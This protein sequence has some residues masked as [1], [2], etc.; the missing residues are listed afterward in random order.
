MSRICRFAM[1]LCLL[2]CFFAI[3]AVAVP[4]IWYVDVDNT[5]DTQD[6]TSWAT[7]YTSIQNAINAATRAGVSAENPAELWVAE[8]RYSDGGRIVT[9][10]GVDTE[11]VI[12]LAAHVHIY[13]GFNGTEMARDERDWENNTTIIDGEGKYRCVVAQNIAMNTATLDGVTLQNGSIALYGDVA[14]R[15]NSGGGLF[16][17]KSSLT[18]MNCTFLKNKAKAGGGGVYNSGSSSPVLTNCTFLENCSDF[19]AGVYNSESSSPMLTNCTF[20][21]NRADSY[22]GGIRNR[23]SSPV[24]MDCTFSENRAG[25]YGGGMCNISSLPTL[26]NCIFFKNSSDVGGGIYNSNSSSATL[27]NCAFSENR[28][29]SHGGGMRNYISSPVLTNCTF[30]W[31]T[32]RYGAGMSNRDSSSPVLMNCTFSENSAGTDGDGIYNSESSL[33]RLK[34]CILWGSDEQIYN[35]GNDAAAVVTYSDIQQAAGVYPGT[36]N[37]NVLPSF[38]ALG[39]H[40]LRLVPGSPCIDVGTTTGAPDTDILGTARPQGAGVDMGA[41]EYFP[42][43]DSDNNGVSDRV[44]GDIDRD[45]D[46]VAD[47]LDLDNDGD[48]LRDDMEGMSDPDGDGTPNYNDM[49][50]D[51]DGIPDSE[52]RPVVFV[53]VDNTSGTEDGASWATAF[54]TIQAG[55][56][57]AFENGGAEVWVAAGVYTGNGRTVDIGDEDTENVIEV[58]EWAHIYGGFSGTETAR[59]ERDWVKNGTIIDG[60]RKRRCVIAQHIAAGAA[61]FDGFTLQKG[62]PRALYKTAC[63]GG[64]LYNYCSLLAVANCNF[65]ENSAGADGGGIYN[66][67]SSL[68]LTNCS[69]LR[70]SASAGGGIYNAESSSPILINCVFSEN[71]VRFRGGGIHNNASSP[72]LMNCT[73]WKNDASI[74]G[75]GVYNSSASS[76]VLTNCI[77]WGSNDQIC[78]DGSDSSP[79]ITYSDVQQSSGVY[80]G[81]GNINAMPQISKCGEHPWRIAL[82]SPCIDAGTA[83]AAPDT[84]IFGT[85]RPLGVGVDMGAHEYVGNEDSDCNGVPDKEEGG[86]DI[87][88]DGIVDAVD[89]DNDGDGLRDDIEGMGDIDGDGI[90]NYDD[91]DSDGDGISDS[92]E[93][94]VVFVDVDNTSGI[95]DGVSWATAF[96]TIQEGIDAAASN[97]GVD[98][99]VAQGSYTGNGRTVKIGGE[100]TENVIEL[101]EWTYLYGGFNG[102]EMQ[103][104]ERDWEKNTTIIDGE[105]LRRC[106]VAQHIVSCVSVFDGFVLQNG[107]TSASSYRF[108]GGMYNYDTSLLL[109]NC[110]FSRNT[111]EHRGG[112][113]YNED[114]LLTLTDCAFSDNTAE[115]GFGGGI[116]NEGSLL[117]L[118]DC[119][120]SDNTAEYRGGGIYNE[121]SL[122][123]LT[124]CTF[125]DNTADY[126]GGMYNNYSSL[127]LTD[128]TF[129]ANDGSGMYNT[130]S[131]ATLTGC[132]FSANDGGG[133]YNNYSSLTLTD[134]T[135]AKNVGGGMSN[136]YSSSP[137]LTDCIFLENTRQNGGGMYNVDSSPTLTDCSFSGNTAGK[138]GGGMYNVKDCSPTLTDCSFSGNTAT[139]SGGGIYNYKGSSPTLTD[140]SFSGNVA[141]ESGG[142][143]YNEALSVPTLGHC[144]FSENV[145]QSGGGVHN[146]GSSPALTECTFLENTAQ[147]GGGMYNEEYSSSVLT[148]CSFSKNTATESGGGM[149]SKESLPKLTYCTFSENT[150]QNG[151]GLYN[152]S[153]SPELTDCII[154]GNTANSYG[155]GMYSFSSSPKAFNCTFSGNTANEAGGAIYHWS[156]TPWNPTGCYTPLNLTNCIVWGNSSPN[157][158]GIHNVT[159]GCSVVTYSC[160]EGGYEGMGNIDTDPRF[161]DLPNGNLRLLADSPCIDAAIAD[162]APAVD[163][164][165]T[166]RPQGRG[167][168]IGAY[169]YIASNAPVVATLLSS[170]NDTTPTWTWTSG[171]DGNGMYRYQLDGESGVWTETTALEY[172]PDSILS[173]GIHTLYVQEYNDAGNWSSSGFIKVTLDTTPPNAPIVTTPSSPT[174]NAMPMW[175]WVSGRD[176]NG[177]YRYQ[178]DGESDV[179]TETQDVSYTPDTVLLNGVHTLYVQERDAAGNWSASGFANVTVDTTFPNVPVVTTSSSPT[180]DATPTWSWT[181]GGDGNGMY[182]YQLDGEE[183]AW[184]ETVDSEYMPATTLSDG[185][186]TLYVQERD[187]AGNWSLSGSASVMVDATSPNAPVVTAPTSPMNDTTPTWTWVSGGAG[188]GMYRYQL[189]GEE[190]A[191]METVDSEY[192]PATVLSD[193]AHTLYVQEC[194]AVGNWSLSGSASVTVDTTSPNAPVVTAPSSPSTDTTPTWTWVSGGAGNGMYRYQLDGEEGVWTET[195]ATSYTPA[196]A[197]SDGTYTLYVQECNAAGTWSSSGSASVE[198]SEKC[199]AVE[200]P[201]FIDA[202]DG[203][204]S[205]R[206]VLSWSPVADAT[207]YQVYRDGTSISDWIAETHFDD[208]TASAPKV[209]STGCSRERTDFVTHEYHV[210]ARNTCG[211]ESSMEVSDTGY[212]G[213]SATKAIPLQSEEIREMVFPMGGA[214][215]NSSFA[216]RIVLEDDEVVPDSVWATLEGTDWIEEGGAW[217]SAYP[218]DN[219]D[220]WAVLTPS[221]PLTPDTEVRLTVGASTV[222]GQ[223]IEPVTH[224]FTIDDA[225]D[226]ENPLVEEAAFGFSAFSDAPVYTLGPDAVFDE[227]VLI[228]LPLPAEYNLDDCKLFYYS[229]SSEHPGWYPAEYV[230]GWLASRGQVITAEDGAVYLQLEVNHGGI[231]QIVHTN[232]QSAVITSEPQ[233]SDMGVFALIFLVLALLS[234]RQAVVLGSKA[235]K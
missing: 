56:D 98:V 195:Q 113:I 53:D 186:H 218:G 111:A 95:E 35:N 231:V 15:V 200:S 232:I 203:L 163:I 26:T 104:D 28:A 62:S 181:S 36:G 157:N 217:H 183:G 159:S 9:I 72:V 151:G 102:T 197:L 34:N 222:N 155:G 99:W 30:S 201:S 109:A 63:S 133:M 17:Y 143:M 80:P 11:N 23:D 178:L 55:I 24:L 45:G 192:T 126:S 205:D 16:N 137:T 213:D 75:K 153:A 167:V 94:P 154:W 127:T 91:T 92:E 97:G 51:G 59:D 117:T 64:G 169:E 6:G 156:Y 158:Q 185:A 214:Q 179:W 166:P 211:S 235:E 226:A 13:G 58:T 90:P 180:N 71:S 68:T 141:T 86:G 93:R 2:F 208:Y 50:S 173:E 61:T 19:G 134:C 96:T 37:I 4:S 172:T 18:V 139:E 182:R 112:G 229:V 60:T 234:S 233:Y 170:T 57:A 149:Y 227:P 41:Y 184:M 216:L 47:L 39:E 129:S 191:W 128:C 190:G 161:V 207:E 160:V 70:N 215:A 79:V 52:E 135:F 65:S 219:S 176:G 221:A 107:K 175:T 110:T 114:S 224:I 174:N 210:V 116:Y 54:T 120:F 122:L 3:P 44:E 187:A 22:G 43:Q 146:N 121:D 85:V 189:D 77:L 69:F 220:G 212:R 108:G 33:P 204:Y 32:A 76:P 144:A 8:G 46:G 194:D 21:E 81:E 87:D 10:E 223:E 66:V 119:T 105:G 124:D 84:D 145:A 171:G 14:S 27:T 31:N 40:A 7:A 67:S 88:E 177:T 78:N 202:S 196:A 20:S 138:S 25:S 49:D 101:L 209:T 82:G 225:L 132:T 147:N 5:S 198:L 38:T 103:R 148:N 42:D 89:L 118:T 188:N 125:F 164:L 150:A 165:G 168:D 48:G 106:V 152:T 228:Q 1:I 100:N 130:F 199:P 206:V 29:D 12:E 115:Y 131:S 142:G 230:K 193:G 140:C 162:D 83:T 123:T 74:H 136:N 73:F